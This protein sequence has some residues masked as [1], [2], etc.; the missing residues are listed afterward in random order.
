MEYRNYKNFLYGFIKIIIPLSYFAP[1]QRHEMIIILTSLLLG[2]L[3][4]QCI[5]IIKIVGDFC[6]FTMQFLKYLC[7]FVLRF[8]I[9]SLCVLPS[10]FFCFFTLCLS[11][12]LNVRN[13]FSFFR[14]QRISFHINFSP[15]G[16]MT[17]IFV[18]LL[19]R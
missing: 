16:P 1:F 11:C 2:H 14:S 12:F 5:Y 19:F 6:D 8:I 4:L 3:I 10:I 15:I 13:L 7:S 9:S 18:I 17:Y